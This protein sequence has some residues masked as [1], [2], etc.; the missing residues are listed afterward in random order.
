M[1]S[2][3]NGY[4]ERLVVAVDVGSTIIRCHV[5]N[6]AAQICGRAEDKVSAGSGAYMDLPLPGTSHYGS[7]DLSPHLIFQGQSQCAREAMADILPTFQGQCW[8]AERR[9]MPYLSI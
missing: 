4:R 9:T 6:S 8:D 5:Y 3:R 2:V 7:H 1:G